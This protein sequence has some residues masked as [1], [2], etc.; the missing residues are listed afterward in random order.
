M[1]RM[2]L[3]IQM[4]MNAIAHAPALSTTGPQLDNRRVLAAL[5]DLVVVAAGAA[6]ILF[7]AD[8]PEWKRVR[9]R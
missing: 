3:P 7:A 6:L 8:A 9:A 5:I 4:R 2:E 1:S